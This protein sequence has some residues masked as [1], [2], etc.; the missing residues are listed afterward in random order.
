MNFTPAQRLGRVQESA[1][2]KMAAATRKLM[3]Q[4]HEVINFSIG[5]PHFPVPASVQE[6]A[7]AAVRAGKSR[8]TPVP[9][10]AEL[11]G[12]ICRKLAEE[13]G[14]TYSPEQISVATGAKQ[15]LYNLMMA[16]LDDGDEV[17]IPAPYWTSYP[18]MVKLAGGTPVILPTT[19]AT[20]FKIS[21]AQLKAAVGP[22]TKLFLL[23][24][25]SNPTGSVYGRA[26]L[27]ALAAVLKGT[28]VW[29]CSDEIYERL[30]LVDEP[31]TSFAALSPDAYAR[32]IT[33]NGFSKAF[34]MTG[35]RLGYAAGSLPLIQAMNLIQGQSTS[36]ANSLAQEAGVRA[37]ELGGDYYAP[38]LAE[39]KA[40]AALMTAGLAGCDLL[41]AYRPDGAFYLFV[42]ISRT[43][44]KKTGEGKTIHSSE[45]LALYLL[46]VGHVSTVPGGG[47]GDDDF[48][49]ISFAAPPD[50][51]RAGARRIVEALAKLT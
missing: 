38:I 42:D 1:T 33:I 9:G 14:L 6:A 2:I 12:R 3:A 31:Y 22:K 13:N 7:I 20:G 51:I 37:L 50:T 45:D 32:T 29:V 28:Q 16:L 24:N 39:L 25:P 10:T 21:P 36:G 46:E 5:E 19:M 11:R 27:Q 23:N 49:R 26:E 40:G 15:S 47:F 48:L 34:A 43:K 8:Y 17:L 18:E 35:W 30:L 44:G 41:T 4:G